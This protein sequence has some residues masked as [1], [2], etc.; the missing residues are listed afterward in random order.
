M[1]TGRLVARGALLGNA[2]GLTV[3]LI[4]AYA[5]AGLSTVDDQIPYVALA[6]LGL[7]LAGLANGMWLLQARQRI[8]STTAQVLAGYRSGRSPLDLSAAGPDSALVSMPGLPFLHRT[9]CLMVRGKPATTSSEVE[10]AARGLG[11]C[12]VCRP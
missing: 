1:I 5:I 2:V 6:L 8:A 12:P 10:A 9:E 7:M 3:I 4:S 11:R